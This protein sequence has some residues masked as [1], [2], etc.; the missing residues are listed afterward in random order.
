MWCSP[1]C[2]QPPILGLIN[3]D[4]SHGTHYA[5]DIMPKFKAQWSRIGYTDAKTGQNIG[6]LRVSTGAKVGVTG[7]V[8]DGWSNSWMN[9]WN[10]E[11]VRDIYPKLRQQ[12]Y[13][14]FISG[15]YARNPPAYGNKDMI[16]LGF[17]Q[18]AFMAAE[19]G[20]SEA[21]ETMLAYADRN[22]KSGVGEWRILLPG[23]V[24]IMRPM[25]PATHAASTAGPAMC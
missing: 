24:M 12:Y 23:A 4:Q 2:N 1:Q 22:F 17:G 3:Y 16:G 8:G 10:P 19:V 11:L 15:A 6:Y 20:D 7:P 13:R 25:P 14:N 18:Y 9:V 5:A 21:R